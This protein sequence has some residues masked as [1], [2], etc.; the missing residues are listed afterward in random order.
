M[1]SSLAQELTL[2][3]LFF[4]PYGALIFENLK[5]GGFEKR[6]NLHK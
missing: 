6:P 1:G 4:L 2:A 5:L 3:D